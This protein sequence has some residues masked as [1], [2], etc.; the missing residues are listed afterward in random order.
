[1]IKLSKILLWLAQGETPLDRVVR[2]T[3]FRFMECVEW[4][5]PG[6]RRMKRV[7]D[8]IVAEEELEMG[9]AKAG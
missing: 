5:L 2:G 4:V 9:I 3:A 8:K 6:R 1:M 7:L